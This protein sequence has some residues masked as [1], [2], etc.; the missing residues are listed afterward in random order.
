[1]NRHITDS[2]VLLASIELSECFSRFN[3]YLYQIMVE[4]QSTMFFERRAGRATVSEPAGAKRAD[5]DGGRF[6]G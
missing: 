6:Y 1:M 4:E 3:K 5:V 2:D